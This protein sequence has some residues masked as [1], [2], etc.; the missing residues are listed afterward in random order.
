[1][2]LAWLVTS[3]FGK[4]RRFESVMDLGAEYSLE[5]DEFELEAGAALPPEMCGFCIMI[6][7]SLNRARTSCDVSLRRSAGSPSIEPRPLMSPG[8]H[9]RA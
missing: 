2:E 9:R 7:A 8:C 4:L 5:Y 3:S 6:A 1:M